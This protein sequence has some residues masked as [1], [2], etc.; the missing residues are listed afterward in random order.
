[1]SAA[2]TVGRRAPAYRLANWTASRDLEAPLRVIAFAALASYVGAAWVAMVVNLPPGRTTLVIV[3]VVAAAT[4]MS[5]LRNPR[6]PRL[7]AQ[8][9]A[10]AIAAGAVALGTMAIGLPARLVLPWHWGELAGNLGTGFGGLWTVDY[11]YTGSVG[12]TRL[13]LL[14]GLPAALGVSLAL[15]FWPTRAPRPRL[16][17]AALVVLLIAYGTAMTVA[18]PSDPLLRGLGLLLLASAWLWLP[19]SG[20]RRGALGVVLVAGCGLIALPVASVLDGKQPWLDY[21]H[22]GSSHAA[23]PTEAFSWDQ[24]YGPLTWP[25]AGREMLTVQSPHP[26]YWRAAVLDEFD[27]TSWVQSTAMGTA[28]LQLPQ[29][30]ATHLN[31]AWIH[32][33]TYTIDHLRSDLAVVAGTPLTPPQLDGLTVVERGLLLPS[34]RSLGEGD[35]YTVRSYIPDPTPSQLRRTPRRFPGAL[36]RDTELTLPGGR[37][38]DV[39]FWG[40]A[41]GGKEDRTLAASAYGNVYSLARRITAG[42]T[43]EYGAVKAIESYLGEHYRYSEFAPIKRLA[44]RTFLLDARRG[45]CQHFSGAMAL[46][47]RMVGV[48]ARVAAGFSPGRPDSNGNYEVTDFDSHSWVEVYFNGI[49]WVTFDPTPAGSPA[50]SRMSGLGASIAAPASSQADLKGDRRRKTNGTNPDV[51]L[52]GPGADGSSLPLSAPWIWGG[53]LAVLAVAGVVLLRRRRSVTDDVD[54]AYLREVTAALRRLR[55]WDLRGATLLGLERRLRAEGGPAAAAY[56]AQ[57]REGRYGVEP[58]GRPTSRDR[59]AVR[60]D[61]A[62]GRG[63]W[64]RMRA[65]AAMPPWGPTA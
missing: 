45:Y 51:A 6:V 24:A 11:P 64:G 20:L 21:R 7:A 17:T 30:S 40:A 12:W 4:A 1:V 10:A 63:A 19:A 56:L 49:G 34:N 15:G 32:D 44:L 48:P 42:Q 43:T 36:G 60:R 50:Q 54:D 9:L 33:V 23:G 47:L 62:A 53:L 22:W 2:A 14:L 29:G 25:R 26:Y 8:V 37:S 18:P 61:L 35:S 46:M 57:L 58:T 41:P 59:R 55:S 39:P 16:R 52:H 27:G 13:A 3:I 65:L 38:V 31:P 5:L 28:P